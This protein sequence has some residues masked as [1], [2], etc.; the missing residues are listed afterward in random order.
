MND[1]EIKEIKTAA[2]NEIWSR[3]RKQIRM[4]A[5]KGDL[6]YLIGLN[7]AGEECYKYINEMWDMVW[8]G[9]DK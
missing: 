3:I 8:K 1:L 9:E 4:H 5:D 7:L 6:D 2:A